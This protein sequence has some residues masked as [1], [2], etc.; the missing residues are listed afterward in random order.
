MTDT[1][2]SRTPTPEAVGGQ[3]DPARKGGSNG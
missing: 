2:A 1:T 3:S